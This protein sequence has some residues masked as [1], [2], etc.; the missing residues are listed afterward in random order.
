M[1]PFDLLEFLILILLTIT[2]CCLLWLLYHQRLR[3][4]P[5]KTPGKPR[6][7][8]TKSPSDCPACR[9]GISLNIQPIRRAVQPWQERKST[10]G[11]KK[12]IRTQGDA[13]PDPDCDCFGI[14]DER[15][16][17]VVGNGKRGKYGHIQALKCQ[18]CQTS[19]SSRRNTPL[20]QLKTQPDRIEICLWLLAEGVDVSALCPRAI[21]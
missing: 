7:W 5:R 11:R 15:V 18:C 10:R 19:F 9:S 20:Y 1:P 21:R 16:H 12:D 17:A 2:T 13:C 6:K 4:K 14:T 8:K 3:K